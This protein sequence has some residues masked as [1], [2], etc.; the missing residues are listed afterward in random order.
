MTPRDVVLAVVGPRSTPCPE[1]L[2]AA[3]DIVTWLQSL[4]RIE[5]ILIARFVVGR[6]IRRSTHAAGSMSSSEMARRRHRKTL[7]RSQHGAID[8]IVGETLYGNGSRKLVEWIGRQ[9]DMSPG[10]RRYLTT[11]AEMAAGE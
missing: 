4:S 6:D 3:T 9:S 11:L 8:R 10:Q 5:C 1:Q 2:Q 7:L